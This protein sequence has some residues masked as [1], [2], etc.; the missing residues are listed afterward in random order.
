[1]RTEHTRDL[2]HLIGMKY[3]TRIAKCY[4]SY[5]LLVQP[6]H[7]CCV[8]RG[9]CCNRETSLTSNTSPS[10]KERTKR[11]WQG[12]TNL[13][14]NLRPTRKERGKRAGQEET[15]LTSNLRPSL[16]E[17]GK[18]ARQEE[19]SLTSNLSPSR[20]ERKKNARGR[21]RLG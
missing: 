7:F 6:L 9:A 5:L 10:R 13:T 14:S 17:R 19:T 4:G 3:K 16:K 1:V 15:S 18:R 20:K 21:E 11:T 8:Y 12:E 2:R